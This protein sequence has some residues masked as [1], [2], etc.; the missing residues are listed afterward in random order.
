V[1][2]SDQRRVSWAANNTQTFRVELRSNGP[3]MNRVLVKHN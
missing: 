2:V 3:G 1:G